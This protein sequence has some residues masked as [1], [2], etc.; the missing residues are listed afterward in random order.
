VGVGINLTL[1]D[2]T[3]THTYTDTHTH[4][5]VRVQDGSTEDMAVPLLS[6]MPMTSCLKVYDSQFEMES[7][8]RQRE[9]EKER[10]RE[11]KR[12]TRCL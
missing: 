11:R 8:V 6:V 3:H 4:H 1:A 2:N 9:R 10:E 5:S 12:E 7:L